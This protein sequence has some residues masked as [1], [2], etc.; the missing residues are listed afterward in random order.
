MNIPNYKNTL[1]LP[2]TSFSMRANLK[3]LE[4]K[5]LSYWEEKDIYRLREEKNKDKEKFILHDGPPYANGRIHLGHALNKILKSITLNYKSLR[6]YNTPFIPGW[7][8]HGLPVEHSLLK[9]LKTTKSKVDVVDFRKKAAQYASKFINLQ[10]KDFW[11]LGVFSLWE[12]PY[13]TFDKEYEYNVLL[14]L[15]ELLKKG[16]IYRGRYP[17]NWCPRCETALA[18]AEVE[19]SEKLSPS[20]YLFFKVKEAKSEILKNQEV[21]FLIWTTTPWT[22]VSNV[23]VAVKPACEYAL[24][25]LEGRQV[26]IM[27]SAL[28]RLEKYFETHIETIRVL[29]S[30]SLEGSLLQ[31]PFLPRISEVVLADFVSEEEGTGCVH[32]APGHGEED[33]SLT[34]KYN[35]DILMPLDEKGVFKEPEEFKGLN[36]DSANNL[37]LKLLGEN[38]NLFRVSQISHSYPHCWRCQGPLIFRATYQ[39]FLNIE[40][41][42]LRQR[43]INFL[44]KINWYPATGKERMQAM[45]E[46]RPDWCLSRQRLWGVP[47]PA[48]KCKSCENIELSAEIIDKVGRVFLKEGSDAWFKQ[49]LDKFSLDELTC[50]K[51]GGRF[52][53]T[54]DILD[55]WFESGASFFSVL[56]NNPD[57]KFPADLYLE[58]SDQHRGWFQVSLIL[59]LALFE[60]PPYRTLLTHGFVVDGEG[61]KMSKSKGNTLSPQEVINEFGAEILRLWSVAADYTEDIKISQD[62]L[63]QIVDIYRKV[64]NTLR[65]LLGNL[66]DFNPQEH[67]FKEDE[68]VEVDRY[69]LIKSRLT[70][71]EIIAYY[72]QFLF[73]K[74]SQKIFSFCNNDLSSFYLDIL[75]DRLYTFSSD[76]PKRRSAQ[77]VLYHILKGFLS[78]IAPIFSFTAEEAYSLLPGKKEVSVFL[79]LLEEPVIDEEKEKSFLN[80]WKRIIFW[81]E[82]ILKEIEKKREEKLIG[83]SQEAAIEL[84][85]SKGDYEDFRNDEEIFRELLIVSQ[86]KISCGEPAIV[87]E[88]VKGKKCLRCWNWYE[89][90]VG[91]AYPEVCKRCEKVLSKSLILSKGG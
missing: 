58:G 25:K 69:F 9:E 85:L 54:F 81:R 80:R 75:K 70:F 66:Y 60:E 13:L 67:N 90:E 74:V 77:F 71:K 76:D 63:K 16:Y 57:L 41:N 29:S 79:S 23:A 82:K 32:I 26:V 42:N 27:A 1:N 64:R 22:L 30:E 87:V 56:K 61:K 11:R 89:Q 35:L 55:V 45:L 7:D 51:C 52:V 38:N 4:P 33:F 28:S 88:R 8:C 15:K 18:L 19:Y 5:I 37:V 53:K 14:V 31:H 34:K 78:I 39:W 83:S 6:G 68:L 50:N 49:D 46:V 10:Q 44:E 62:I 2:K 86:F 73:Y 59:S 65:F 3:Q 17:V 47:I 24:V 40:H 43:L 20:L 91:S 48:L 21:Y 84:I 36:T 12:K 72:E